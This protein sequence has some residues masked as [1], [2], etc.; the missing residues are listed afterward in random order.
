MKN[1]IF[2]CHFD[3]SHFQI[4]VLLTCVEKYLFSYLQLF[5]VCW[6]LQLTFSLCVSV[7]ITG[8]LGTVESAN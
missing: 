7:Y 2:I 1:L 6:F 5:V 3:E 8:D 4:A